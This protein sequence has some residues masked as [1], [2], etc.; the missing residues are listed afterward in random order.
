MCEPFAHLG[1]GGNATRWTRRA[2]APVVELPEIYQRRA[3]RLEGFGNDEVRR[4]LR[5]GRLTAV[6]RG[7]Y[8]LGT[9]PDGAEVRHMLQ[10]RAELAHLATG[11][12]VSHPSAAVL[13][14]LPTWGCGSTAC[15]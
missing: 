13:H 8:V 9:P 2:H 4:L 7:C 5:A 11:A 10:V 1:I 14:G 15:T 6:R 12:V 3:L